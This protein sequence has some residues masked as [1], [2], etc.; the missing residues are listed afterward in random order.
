MKK[1]QKYQMKIVIFTAAKNHCM[2]H[3]RVFVMP[4][5]HGLSYSLENIGEGNLGQYQ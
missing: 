4:I 5:S 2:L 1:V 3:G